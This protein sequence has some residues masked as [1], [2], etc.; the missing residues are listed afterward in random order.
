MKGY[1]KGTAKALCTVHICTML[2]C[3]PLFSQYNKQV[4]NFGKGI[5]G[6]FRIFYLAYNYLQRIVLA[7]TL[8]LHKCFL[9]RPIKNDLSLCSCTL[10]VCPT[11]PNL[12]CLINVG[13]TVPECRSHR[14]LLRV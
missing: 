6:A 3:N 4:Q 12:Y 11:L 13:S 9:F 5:S 8:P 10:R 2:T 1:S 7:A 14:F